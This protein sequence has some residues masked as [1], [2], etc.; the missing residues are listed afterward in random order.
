MGGLGRT[1]ADERVPRSCRTGPGGVA[2]IYAARKPDETVTKREGP[3]PCCGPLPSVSCSPGTRSLPFKTK[4]GAPK[5]WPERANTIQRGQQCGRQLRERER[6][7]SGAACRAPAPPPRRLHLIST[8]TGRKRTDSQ[9]EMN[10]HPAP[11]RPDSRPP[12]G[13]ILIIKSAQTSRGASEARRP[14]NWRTGGLASGQREHFA[15]SRPRRGRPSLER[16]RRGPPN[17]GSSPEAN[18][19]SRARSPSL[20]PL[21]GAA[22]REAIFIYSRSVHLERDEHHDVAHN[23]DQVQDGRDDD[24]QDDLGELPLLVDVAEEGVEQAAAC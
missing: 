7:A 1:R 5:Q 22:R 6:A 9:V 15:G 3:P 18:S 16:A 11:S 10:L 12:R 19:L 4:P 21:G 20:A 24:D 23:G 13:L 14:A 8:P 2:H 17:R